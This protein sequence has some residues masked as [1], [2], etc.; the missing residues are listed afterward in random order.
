MAGAV[1]REE[2]MKTANTLEHL[3]ELIAGIAVARLTTGDR[4]G[5]LHSRPMMVL[6][7]MAEDSL[8]FF[9]QGNSPIVD[10]VNAHHPVNIS[11]VDSTQG[12]YVSLSG[13]ARVVTDGAKKVALWEQRLATW[14]PK[15]AADPAVVLIRVEAQ[16]AE[17]WEWGN[18]REVTASIEITT[19]GGEVR[20]EKIS[21]RS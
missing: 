20:N 6:R 1:E 7:T 5:R 2:I 17:S 8:W 15:G 3:G 9:T 21:F 16:E 4:T 10:D 13:R 19:G 11:Y 18:E 12:R 14:L